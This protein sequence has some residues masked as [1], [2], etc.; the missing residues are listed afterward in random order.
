MKKINCKLKNCFGIDYFEHQFNFSKT[1]S[2]AIYARN[3][4]MKTSFAK[5]FKK[6]QE[7]KLNDIKDEI[8]ETKSSIDI[9]VDDIDIDKEEIFV[10]NS[11]ED[12]YESDSIADLLVDE[13]IKKKI[14]DLL[15]E[16]NKILKRLEK[17]SGLKVQRTKQGKKYYELEPVIV[18]DMNLKENSILLNLS[19]LFEYCLQIR[20][21]E[22]NFRPLSA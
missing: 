3:G 18:S 1:N 9:K 15:K 4:L 16:K 10:I 19:E 21:I 20:P 14:S 2:I 7:N 6:I 8:F 12:Y 22:S 11:F 17:Y 5:T 13:K